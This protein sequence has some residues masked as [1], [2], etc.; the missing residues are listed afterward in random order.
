VATTTIL[1][2]VIDNVVGEDAR[3]EVLVPV[4]ADPHDF[5][6]SAA[7]IAEVNRADLVVAIG[8]GLEEGMEDTLD[9]AATDGV[10]VF[11]VGP[12]LDPLPLKTTEHE[13]EHE[14]HEGGG[15]TEGEEHDHEGVDPHVWLDP[16]RMAEATRLIAAQL[17]EIDPSSDWQG[18]ADQYAAQLVAADE[19]ISAELESIPNDQRHLVT[20]HEALGYF[21][22]RYGFEVVGVIIPGGSTLADPS[23]AQL[24]ELVEVMRREGVT[25]I[26]GETTEPSA[27]A[28]AVA[29]ELGND[30]AVV[31]LFTESLGE[32]GSGADTLIGMLKTN[33]AL[34]SKALGEPR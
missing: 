16:L 4:G 13:E 17:A 34:I 3:V 1:G 23:S 19:E 5:Q 33:S 32:P 25:V 24:A 28:E 26:F 10:R 8:L 31:E 21:A 15:E 6:A 9:S 11:E 18:R 27:L 22:N 7:Q 14:G 12:L 29:F 20:N 2:D 30:V